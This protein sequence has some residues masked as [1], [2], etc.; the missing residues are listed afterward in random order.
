MYA[1][2][3]HAANMPVVVLTRLAPVNTL[4]F[5]PRDYMR[6]DSPGLDRDTARRGI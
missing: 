1:N 5:A 4:F 3:R 2:I 6:P